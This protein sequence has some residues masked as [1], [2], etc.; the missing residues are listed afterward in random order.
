MHN[1]QEIP[2]KTFDGGDEI[3]Y[4]IKNCLIN[5]KSKIYKDILNQ[6]TNPSFISED[7]E[8]QELLQY[9]ILN[10]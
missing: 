5:F 1:T 9:Y 6:L 10:R 2:Q 8:F 7:E 3:T 4:S